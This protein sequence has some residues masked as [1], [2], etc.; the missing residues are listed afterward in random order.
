MGFWAWFAI[1]ISITTISLA[2]YVFIGL[3]LAKKAKQLEPAGARLQA[4]SEKLLA[5]QFADVSTPVLVAALDQT[6]EQV[7]SG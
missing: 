4:L 5:T 7:L 2:T 6:S 3:W 1:F